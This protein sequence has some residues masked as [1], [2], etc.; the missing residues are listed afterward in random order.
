[1]PL[2]LYGVGIS[3]MQHRLQNIID[4]LV[5][6]SPPSSYSDFVVSVDNSEAVNAYSIPFKGI[7]LITVNQGLW[8]PKYGLV[9]K[10]NDDELAAILGHEIGH[11][12]F[13]IGIYQTL[14]MEMNNQIRIQNCETTDDSIM[15]YLCSQET[16]AD[17]LGMIYMKR[18]GY[19]PQAAVDI[20]T[21]AT[22]R[23]NTTR[24]ISIGDVISLIGKTM[25]QGA[26]ESLTPPSLRITDTHPSNEQRLQ[27]LRALS[28]KL[29][30]S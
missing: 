4:R 24:D 14:A 3:D 5:R 30:P 10:E 11:C 12:I 7:C 19:N 20:W 18:A 23:D 27:N 17:K 9:K 15:L 26:L 25:L 2:S 1:M 21:R 6:N 8:D 28:Q 22:E 29:N 16:A 13:E